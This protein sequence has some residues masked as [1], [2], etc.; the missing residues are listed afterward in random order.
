M[1]L[2][3]SIVRLHL[4][5]QK[6]LSQENAPHSDSILTPVVQSHIVIENRTARQG[7][8]SHAHAILPK[9]IAARGEKS[10][11][12]AFCRW[13]AESPSSQ[14]TQPRQVHMTAPE[15]ERVAWY[16]VEQH[17]GPESHLSRCMRCLLYSL[18]LAG[19]RRSAH[20]S[21]C[22]ESLQKEWFLRGRCRLRRR[23]VHRGGSGQ[24]TTCVHNNIEHGTFHLRPAPHDQIP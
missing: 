15:R 18:R 8:R 21:A 23:I 17:R 4:Q 7:P 20:C 13:K 1:R 12:A 3:L 9:N 16:H 2:L 19:C 11:T 14:V 6:N 10:F 24:Y 5:N 22:S